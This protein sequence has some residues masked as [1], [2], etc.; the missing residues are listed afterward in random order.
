MATHS[1]R[2]R[3]LSENPLLFLTQRINYI[4]KIRI[5]YGRRLAVASDV[6]VSCGTTCNYDVTTMCDLNFVFSTETRL[7][8]DVALTPIAG[9]KCLHTLTLVGVP[10]T[11]HLYSLFA[12]A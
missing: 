8:R 9:L 6:Y 12:K 4:F 5:F 10:G 11:G 3:T 1:V 7:V 2:T